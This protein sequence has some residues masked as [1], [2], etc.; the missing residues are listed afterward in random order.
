LTGST[1]H[2]FLPDSR[3]LPAEVQWNDSEDASQSYDDIAEEGPGETLSLM[4]EEAP[5]EETPEDN[6]KICYSDVFPSSK[7]GQAFEPRKPC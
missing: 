7:A 6:P 4:K 2:G 5:E 3:S 1:A